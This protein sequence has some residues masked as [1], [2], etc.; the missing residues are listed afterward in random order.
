ML[1]IPSADRPD[2][3]AVNVFRVRPETRRQFVDR[4]RAAADA[5]D[6]AGLLS[7][8][9]LCSKDG[10]HVIN[11]MHWAG[12]EALDRAG[13]HDSVI[14]ATRVA[15]RQF[16]EGAGPVPYEVVEIKPG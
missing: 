9:L 14:A 10:T 3:F 2:L 13:A 16:I 7:M 5:A 1:I 12:K 15:I 4:I 11:H 6:I 8:H